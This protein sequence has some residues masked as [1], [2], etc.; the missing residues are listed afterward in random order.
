MKK[1]E[2]KRAMC[3][4]LGRCVMELSASE[5]IGKYKDI[6]L[7]GCLHNLSFDR[8]FEGTRAYYVY[9]LTEFFRDEMFFLRPV[10]E[11]FSSLSFAADSDIF[12]HLCELLCCFAESGNNF[13][14]RVL[15]EKYEKLFSFIS[16]ASN[17]KGREKGAD[18]FENLSIFL[19]SLYGFSF[20]CK[21]CKEIGR[22]FLQKRG[23]DFSWFYRNGKSKFGKKRVEM[24][25]K[26]KAA[27][28]KEYA[29]FYE[30]MESEDEKET[31][32]NDKEAEAARLIDQLKRGRENL[33]DRFSLRR[34]KNT[35]QAAFL[36]GMIKSEKDE[37]RVAQLLQC[38]DEDCP[39]PSEELIGYYE[40]GSAAL[41]R[42][43]LRIL[44][45]RQESGLREFALKA[46]RENGGNGRAVRLL[47]N[48]FLSG[49]EKILLSVLKKLKVNYKDGDNWH[50][51]FSAVLSKEFKKQSVTKEVCYTIYENSLCSFCRGS[52]FRRLA[53]KRWLTDTVLTECQYDSD[54]D[55]RVWA[56]K[57]IN[58]KNHR[59]IFEK[60]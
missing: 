48:N 15:K 24:Y 33:Q 13:A 45:D 30:R 7:W 39:I 49:D 11:K 52:A 44:S 4:G 19:N 21:T 53:Q 9:Q 22:L 32:P 31:T 55:I 38:F 37:N 26:K 58:R 10:A 8:F 40:K 20:F 50:D 14:E 12:A 41:K 34:I 57:R 28:D 60:R 43:V 17:R 5:N 51:A 1:S 46:L 27:K 25:L 47:L 18:N 29:A 56:E 36:V 6:V 59:K 3:C 54:C 2:F 35:E 16:G 42:E 23:A